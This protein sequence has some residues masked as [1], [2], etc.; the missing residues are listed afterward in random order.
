ME[1][2]GNVVVVEIFTVNGVAVVITSD[3]IV[4]FGV[5]DVVIVVIF[6]RLVEVVFTIGVFVIFIQYFFLVDVVVFTIGFGIVVVVVVSFH[7][8]VINF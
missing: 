6:D 1:L 3:F 4:A 7:D 2:I 5:E 8:V